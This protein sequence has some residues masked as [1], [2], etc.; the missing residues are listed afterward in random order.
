MFNTNPGHIKKLTDTFGQ[1]DNGTDR[2]ISCDDKNILNSPKIL[3][4]LSHEVRTYMNSIVAFS[5]LQSNENCNSMERKEYSDHILSSCEQLITLFDN[6]LDSAM[7]DSEPPITN[8]KKSELRV[9][10]QNLAIELNSSLSKFDRNQVSLVLEETPANHK[11]FME[12]E[13]IIRVIK[14]LFQN[15]IEHT[16]SGYV[17]LG[18]KRDDKRVIFYV[19]DSGSGYHL[20]KQLLEGEEVHNLLVK[21]NNTFTAI[22]LILAQKL[23]CSMGGNLWIEPNGVNGSGNIFLSAGKENF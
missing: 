8:L 9:F 21:N 1:G 7:L 12:E 19:I 23:I 13:K 10:M 3:T 14:N 2:G 4:G 5:F 17:K 11:V 22:G 15:A 20:N 18:Y 6:F 16:N